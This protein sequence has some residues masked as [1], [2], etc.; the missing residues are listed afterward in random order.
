LAQGSRVVKRTAKCCTLFEYGSQPELVVQRT[1]RDACVE[2]A[3]FFRCVGGRTELPRPEGGPPPFNEALAEPGRAHAARL[4]RRGQPPG[5]VHEAYPRR[6]RI[7]VVG[8]SQLA[9][10]RPFP[11]VIISPRSQAAAGDEC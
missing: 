3:D 4:R 5:R 8:R 11:L 6:Q 1:D 10:G 2:D 9:P 7:G